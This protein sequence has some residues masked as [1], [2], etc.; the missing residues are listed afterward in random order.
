MC[1]VYPG[2][3]TEAQDAT[4]GFGRSAVEDIYVVRSFR[5]SRDPASAFCAELRT[6]FGGATRE[7]RYTF[8]SVAIS[9][10]GQV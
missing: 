9:T 3:S 5:E 8:R 4:G 1:V 10:S 6:G 2:G 7:D